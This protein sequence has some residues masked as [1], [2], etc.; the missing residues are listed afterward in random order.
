MVDGCEEHLFVNAVRVRV[1]ADQLLCWFPK[2]GAD[3]IAHCA[4]LGNERF[5]E[6]INSNEI[7]LRFHGGIAAPCCGCFAAR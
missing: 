1:G 3:E 7:V 6:L 5:S 2:T 4:K